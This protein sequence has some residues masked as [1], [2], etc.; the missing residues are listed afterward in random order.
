MNQNLPEGNLFSMPGTSDQPEIFDTILKTEN[1]LIERI[2]TT[3]NFMAPGPWFDQENDE[4]VVLLEGNATIEFANGSITELKKGDYLFIGARQKHRVTR[5]SRDPQ[6]LW[7][8]VHG[9]L[10]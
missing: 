2:I 7:L 1:L 3:E 10:K 9:K 6:C 5:A 8:A 4:W